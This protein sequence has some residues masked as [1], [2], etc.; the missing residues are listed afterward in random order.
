MLTP[1]DIGLLILFGAVL[2]GPL[3]SRPVEHNLELFFLVIGV[4]AA[5]IAGVWRLELVEEALSEPLLKGIVPAVLAAGL[6]FHFGKARIRGALGAISRRTHLRVFVFLLVALLGLASSFITA[7]IAA[8][9]LVEVMYTLPLERRARVRVTVIACFA[10]GLGAALTPVGEPL[11]TIAITKLKGEPHHAGFLFLLQSLGIYVIPGVL[12]FAAL[13]ALMA[14]S[15]LRDDVGTPATEVEASIKDVLIRALKVYVFVM[16]LLVLG[17]GF[18]VLID[19]YL[20]DVPAQGLFW[21]NMSSAVLD[22]ATLTAAEI[23]P[24]LQLGQIKSAL[25]ALL[26]SGGMLIP[27]NIPNI[28]SAN[29]LAITSK[30]WARVG[31]PVGLVALVAYFVWLYYIPF[32]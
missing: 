27:G 13:G 23:G 29:Q 1:V 31:V 5:T 20:I 26:V 2:M 15:G 14:T 10:I 28:I 6:L 8:L 25:L 17:D 7:I 24:S 9:V 3:V 32:P 30:E 11:S 12:A 21:V 16:A 22:N 18:R 19:K 4:A